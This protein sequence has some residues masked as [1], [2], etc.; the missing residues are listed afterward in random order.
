MFF[1]CGIWCL[2]GILRDFLTLVFL[3]RT[4]GNCKKVKSD[5]HMQTMGNQ[6]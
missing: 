3:S 1:V 4:E 6:T 2:A 5:A